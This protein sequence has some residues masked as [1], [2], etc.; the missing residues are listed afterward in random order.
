M[1]H[2][3]KMPTRTK[4]S[5]LE[6]Y[7]DKEC[8]KML[9]RRKRGRKSKRKVER[10]M[11]SKERR[12]VVRLLAYIVVVLSLVNI[13]IFTG[14]T[15]NSKGHK[16]SLR[17]ILRGNEIQRSLLIN[18][19]DGSCD[20]TA[21]KK[22][23]NAPQDIDIFSTL[24]AG[25]PGS[26]KRAAFMQLEGMTEFRAS[27]DYN[28]TAGSYNTKFAFKKTNYPH[29]DGIWDWHKQMKQVVLLVR[30]PRWALPS[31]HHLLYEI[32]Y[33]DSWLWS[34]LRQ[35]ESYTKRAPIDDWIKWRDTRFD[36]E[37]KKWGWFLDYWMEGGIARDMLSNEF[38]TLEHFKRLTQPTM[39]ASPELI[40]AQDALGDV[41]AVFDDHCLTDM[42]CNPVAIASFERM[43]NETTGPSE[44]ERF[45]AVIE[46]KT[47]W[48]ISDKDTRECV[49]HQM[50]VEG[51]SFVNTYHDREGNGPG[52]KEFNFTFSQMEKI[53]E[54]L[55]RV[56]T[57]YSRPGWTN[58]TIA[59]S[60]LGYVDEYIAEN[61]AEM[62]L[63]E[64]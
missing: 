5:K 62:S 46:N 4:K 25:F 43:I 28:I 14:I 20:Y 54:E 48:P 16:F 57:K 59:Q 2:M 24:V 55:E 12:S 17:K 7:L 8:G 40:A 18:T 38:T 11:H 30:N 45:V 6:L 21:V 52:E 9:V 56:K 35:Y 31:Y 26:G 33:S 49:W 10:F 39:Y 34:Y 13:G 51:K 37:I 23:R 42:N 36:V 32:E 1:Q 15:S 19:E 58:N 41:S 61:M 3:E 22:P 50:I 27:D 47:A 44:I 63:L 64:E 60:L 53:Q 29:H